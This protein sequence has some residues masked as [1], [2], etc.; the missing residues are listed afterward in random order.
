ME[1]SNSILPIIPF[2]FLGKLP[3]KK[4][5]YN[6]TLYSLLACFVV[7]FY[8]QST[9]SVNY[10]NFMSKIDGVGTNPLSYVVN[11]RSFL[12]L[13]ATGALSAL[14]VLLSFGLLQ[15]SNFKWGKIAVLVC[16]VASILTFRR[17]SL[18]TSFFA[19]LYM[20]FLFLFILK[21]SKVKFFVFEILV[22]IV[23]FYWLLDSNPELFD[24]LFERFTSLS[25][26]IS[27]RKT[28][29]V[30]GVLDIQRFVFGDGLGRYGH[31]AV[32]YS[33]SHIP[34]GNYLRMFYELGI[35]GFSI[36]ILIIVSAL[37]KGLSY[38]ENNYIGLGVIIMV[39]LQA[40]GSD[41]FSFQLVAPIFW[42][43]IG[44][45][46]RLKQLEESESLI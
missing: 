5:F 26:A 10:M 44:R 41:M 27:S 45:S 29:G 25:D 11:Y 39:C 14:C 13:T 33:D 36:F 2:Y 31:K 12:G 46:N 42:Y 32:A 16:F 18:Y 37:Y 19:L 1:F 40:V 23:F 9:T 17:A 15:N 35:I 3:G 8:L 38:I 4:S 22:F 20:N 30:G 7:G 24:L 34:D 21:G 28:S 6:I 43:S